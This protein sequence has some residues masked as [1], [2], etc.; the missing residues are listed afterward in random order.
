[1]SPILILPLLI[2]LVCTCLAHRGTNKSPG[3]RPRQGE[4]EEEV[5]RPNGPP[6][7]PL[8]DS[9][10]PRR[11]DKIRAR[12]RSV[13]LSLRHY[14]YRFGIASNGL[15]KGFFRQTLVEPHTPS[16]RAH[17]PT[18]TH[19]HQ[20]YEGTILKELRKCVAGNGQSMVGAL[21]RWSVGALQTN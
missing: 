21:E 6:T 8:P 15:F 16:T 9:G 18:H 12:K 3:G 19:T 11:E 13:L 10:H 5:S 20:P 2:A 17:T 7:T 1:V 14:S 4:G